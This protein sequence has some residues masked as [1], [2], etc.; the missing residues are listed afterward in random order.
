MS[1]KSDFYLVREWIKSWG[2]HV[3]I[4]SLYETMYTRQPFVSGAGVQRSVPHD[5][6]WPE[7]VALIDQIVR[8]MPRV[9]A[10]PITAKFVYRAPDVKA[11]LF[12]ETSKSEYR[13]LVDRGIWYA[14]GR[15]DG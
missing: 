10:G 6:P 1:D 15:I 7:H 9:L 11:S 13:N 14:V 3:R 12:F 8:S 5:E 4:D 2:H